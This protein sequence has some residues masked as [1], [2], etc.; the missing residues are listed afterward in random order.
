MNSEAFALFNFFLL[1]HFTSGDLVCLPTLP[2]EIVPGGKIPVFGGETISRMGRYC[3]ICRRGKR[4]AFAI[5]DVEGV[6]FSNF[7]L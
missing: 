1:L 3:I 4:K 5:G 7:F 2:R 6:I